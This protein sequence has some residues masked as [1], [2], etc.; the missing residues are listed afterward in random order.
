MSPGTASS[1]PDARL[2]VISGPLEG[3]IFGFDGGQITIGREPA[4][5][6]S[7][8]DSSLSRNHCRIERRGTEFRLMD[9]GSRNGTLVN[10]TAVAEQALKHGDQIRIGNC[11]IL[12][13]SGSASLPVTPPPVDRPSE[14][15]VVLRREDALYLRTSAGSSPLPANERTVRDL[16]ILL[17]FSKQVSSLRGVDELRRTVIETLEEIAP[18]DLIAVLLQDEGTGEL[19]SLTAWDRRER[20]VTEAVVSSTIVSRVLDE[21]VAILSND[22]AADEDLHEAASLMLRKVRSVAAVPLSV[23]DKAIGL[24][25]L[26]GTD[27]EAKFDEGTMQ[28]LA[29]LGNIA[30]LAIEN[31]RHF[32][33]LAGENRRLQDE[34]NI[35]H[36]MIG[37]SPAIKEVFQFISRVAGR[38]STVLITGESGTGKE[39][40]ARAVHRNSLRSGKPF[41]AINCAAITETLLESELFGHEKGAFTGAVAQKKGKLEVADGGTVFLDEIGDLA[42]P[43]Q[44]KLLRV[45]Q[46]REFERVGGTQ[47]DQAGHPA[48]RGNQPRPRVGGAAGASSATTSTTG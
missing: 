9:L 44:A 47:A 3:Q 32:E 27:P 42:P 45:L 20:R 48:D 34:L 29:A 33:W 21:G 22:V 37:D 16:D 13:R 6:I 15:T 26:D 35:Q 7:I 30:A 2:E 31:A 38:D 28:L 11:V 24:L 17:R 8:P 23:A 36:D 19:S 25:Y 10:G 5:N 18:A 1:Q 4:N 12:F 46:E 14:L 40:V 39:L 43:L 41:V